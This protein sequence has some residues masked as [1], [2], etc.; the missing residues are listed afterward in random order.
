M[1]LTS[2]FINQVKKR[3]DY[4]KKIIKALSLM[5]I[6][7]VGLMAITGCNS[8][9][10]SSEYVDYVAETKLDLTAA[11]TSVHASATLH[12][13]IDGDTTHFIVDGID[14]TFKARYLAVD[15]PE[16]TG[17][18]EKWGKSASLFTKSKVE[19]AESLIVESDTT[20][21]DLDS[22]GTRYLAWV[23]Y[24][25]S[26]TE[27]YR[28]LNIELL[29]E[30]FSFSKNTSSTKYGD[31]CTAAAT[32]ARTLELRVY[33]NDIDPNYYYGDAQSITLKELRT[34]ISEYV[35]KK[36][37]FE[38]LVTEVYSQTAYVED[39]D[40]ETETSYGISIYMSYTSYDMITKGNVVQFTGTCTYYATGGTYQISGISHFATLPNRADNLKLISTEN[41]VVPTEI[42][43]S[44]L[45]TNGALILSTYV[46]MSNLTVTSVYTTAS[47]DSTGAMTLTCR[48]S[49]NNMV[50][51]RTEVLK[52]SSN[53]NVTASYFTDKSINVTGIVD[54]YSGDYQIR[55]FRLS[56]VTIN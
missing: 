18:V 36:V 43:S 39:Y 42:T 27:D 50:Y 48:D 45:T 5:A 9:E 21:W 17:Q 55:L 56:E 10:S 2:V 44:D 1:Q 15:T 4:M 8:S 28:C 29:Q 11:N 40:E 54:Y 38:G 6:S 53:N 3:V 47:G 41:E 20:F 32:Q 49:S 33:G 23:W 14:D 46:S 51:V 19:S 31:V 16:S 30:G 24:R 26:A 37:C 12:A 22:T 25:T 52:D 7:V 13:N 34:N 35:D